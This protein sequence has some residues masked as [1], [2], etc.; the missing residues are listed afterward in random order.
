ML[1]IGGFSWTTSK[2]PP[3]KIKGGAEGFPLAFGD[4]KGYFIP[5]DSEIIEKSGAE[6]AFSA[7]YRNRDGEKVS[8]YLGYRES[9]FLENENFFHSPTVCL[10]ASGWETK[11]ILTHK[12]TNVP[13]FQNIT[14]TKMLA[15]HTDI[16]QLVYFWFQTKNKATPDKNIHRFHLTLHAIRRDNTHA[17]FIRPITELRPKEDVQDAEERMD[18]F[19]REM[20]ITLTQFLKENQFENTNLNNKVN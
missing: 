18:G 2:L 14:I 15:E 13:G 4:W 5:V 3:L 16:R 8:L 1:I 17:L 19:V 6:A 12:I 11:E 7:V 20:L 10:P 9:A